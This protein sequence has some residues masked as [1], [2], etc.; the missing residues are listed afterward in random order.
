[1]L[2]IKNKKAAVIGF[3]KRTG[4]SAA[5]SLIDNGA[6]VIVSDVKSPDQLKEER[7]ML[8]GY[9][10]EYDLNGHSDKP[11]TSD[12]IVVSPGVPLDTPFFE[13]VKKKKIPVLSEIELAYHLNQAN[14]I[15]ITG[16]NG[17]TTTTSLTGKILQGGNIGKVR[18][19][20][21]IGTPFISV[22]EDLSEEDWVVLEVSSFQ[23][24]TIHDFKPDISMFLNFTPDHLDR[25]KNKEEYWKAKRK[26]FSNQTIDDFALINYDDNRV[27]EAARNCNAEKYNISL[28]KEINQGIYLKEGGL[29][30]NNKE[31]THKKII[32]IK[33]IPLIGLHNVQNTAFAVMAALLV[34][35]DKNII[36]K[37]IT[38]FNPDGH[39]LEILSS[40]ENYPLIIDDSK[41]TNP[42]AA[43]NALKSIQRPI[44]LIAGGQDRGANFNEFSRLISNNVKTLILLGETRSQLKKEVLK[45][46]FNNIYTVEDMTEAV[47]IAL[48]KLKKN[49][50]LLLS[51]GCPSW[52]MYNSYKERGKIFKQEI[53]SQS[54]ILG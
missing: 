34:G 35:I 43:V 27:K 41:A 15:A 14:I 12:F 8:K 2:K 49:D 3:S 24:E 18:V 46:G 17:K 7:K 33:D 6:E 29:Y 16:T 44:V 32:D 5:K 54:D 20:G 50:C 21:N 9:N 52:D 31:I 47:S 10:V 42:D 36:Q 37:E 22:V 1:M 23:L 53:E 48:A 38:N 30:L 51:P 4:V 25:H 45:N 28:K 11:L 19:A 26:I 13:K 40:E 39:R